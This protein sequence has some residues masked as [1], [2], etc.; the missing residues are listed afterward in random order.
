MKAP[1]CPYCGSTSHLTDSSIIYNG[2]SFG[3]VWIC[4]NYP[5]CDAFVGVHKSNNQP[6][7]R[8]ANGELRK[9]KINAHS[10]FDALWKT[11]GGMTRQQAYK[12]LSEQLG[13]PAKETH[14]GMFD[15]EMCNKVIDVCTEHHLKPV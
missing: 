4:A 1:I 8:L 5:A 13:L 12:W 10:I 7:G 14:I 15:V 6:L 9:A 3:N 11:Q 2:R